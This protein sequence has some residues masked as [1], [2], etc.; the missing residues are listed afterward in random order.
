MSQIVDN[1]LDVLF[2]E[3]V[4]CPIC[5]HYRELNHLGIC[6][7]CQDKLTRCQVEVPDAQHMFEYIGASY[8]YNDLAKALIHRYKLGYERNLSKLF[9]KMIIEK[10]NCADICIDSITWIPCSVAK[11]RYK[12]FDHAEDIAVELAKLIDRPTHRLLVNANHGGAQKDRSRKERLGAMQDA[13]ICDTAVSVGGHVLIVDDIV[14]TGATMHSAAYT[15]RLG[16]PDLSVSGMAAFYT[17]N[18][19]L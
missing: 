15:L 10:L 9:A 12:G 11:K 16:N 18:T 14:T 4:Q 13:F 5:E 2:P 7:R 8:V 17:T 6:Q 3:D 1:I 19:K